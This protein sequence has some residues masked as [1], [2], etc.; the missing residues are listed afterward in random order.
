[1]SSWLSDSVFV[2]E[3]L[4]LWSSACRP[5]GAT[6]FSVR[7]FASQL[8]GYVHGSAVAFT[9]QR[10]C[11][12][13]AASGEP[14]E[15]L[16]DGGGGLGED[17]GRPEDGEEEAA[18]RGASRSAERASCASR[19]VERATHSTEHDTCPADILICFISTSTGYSKKNI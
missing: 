17:G 19:F 13:G 9:V 2:V 14:G 18:A 8:S 4:L 7:R 1:M 5:C 15:A 10:C 16:P 12:A 6:V 11:C 3:R